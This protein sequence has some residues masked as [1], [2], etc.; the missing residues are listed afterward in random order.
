MGG[1]TGAAPRNDARPA[2]G[3]PAR[4]VP[5]AP[6]KIIPLRCVPALAQELVDQLDF[7]INDAVFLVRKAMQSRYTT[8]A[9]RE[10]VAQTAATAADVAQARAGLFVCLT[11]NAPLL[12]MDP[13]DPTD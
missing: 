2:S 10:L 4:P 1:G 11:V 5:A 9:L 8:E 7:N 12:D 13:S 6:E 3:A